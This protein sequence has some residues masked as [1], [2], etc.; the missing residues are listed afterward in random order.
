VG[1][2][3]CFSS[4]VAPLLLLL[5]LLLMLMLLLLLMLE[6]ASQWLRIIEPPDSAPDAAMIADAAMSKVE[7]C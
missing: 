7:L 3:P 5:L 4:L 6:F 2:W 1:S